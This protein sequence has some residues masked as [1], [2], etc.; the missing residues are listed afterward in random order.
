MIRILFVLSIVFSGNPL[1]AAAA[2]AI[3]TVAWLLIH[4]YTLPY[5]E[6]A[7]DVLQ[8]F[9]LVSLMALGYAGV[10]FSESKLPEDTKNR[11]TFGGAFIIF[12]MVGTFIVLFIREVVQKIKIMVSLH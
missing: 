12:L 6:E 2:L 4:V 10:L 3:I 9:L 8:T 1:S 5:V 7:T 11:V